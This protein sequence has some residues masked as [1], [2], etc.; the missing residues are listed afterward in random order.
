MSWSFGTRGPLSPGRR[1][2]NGIALAATLVTALAWSGCGT[3][4]GGENDTGCDGTCTQEALTADEV[5]TILAGGVAEAE[6]LGLD[7]TIAVLDRVGNVLA[8]FRMDGAAENTVISSERAGVAEASF[9]QRVVPTAAAAISKAGTGAY[10]SSQ[11][12]AFTTRTASQIVQE[13]FNPRERGRVGGPLFGVQFSQLPCGDVVTRAADGRRNG[14]VGGRVGPHRLPLGLAADPGGLPIYKDATDGAAR[15][16][17]TLV[18]G[19]GVE[20]GCSLLHACGTCTLLA[21]A[22]DADPAA[23]KP[24]R[25]AQSDCS[26]AVERIYGLDADVSGIDTHLEE[27]IAAA[28]VRGFEAPTDRRANRISALGKFL[29]YTDDENAGVGAI[30][31]CAELTGSLVPVDGYTDVDSCAAITGGERLGTADSGILRTTFEGMDAEILVDESGTPRFPPSDGAGLDASEVRTILAEALAITERVRAQ[32]RRPL[33][34]EARVSIAVVDAEGAL[35]GLVRSPDAPVFGIDVAVQ[36]A[37]TAAFFSSPDARSELEAAPGLEVVD[38]ALGA[39][40]LDALSMAPTTDLVSRYVGRLQTF[41]TENGSIGGAPIEA[42][43]VLTGA[44]AFGDRAGG[45]LSRPFYP[46]GINGNA[47]G[48]LSRPFEIWSPFSTGL[49]LDLVF[50]NVALASC[51]GVDA[52]TC[53]SVAALANGIQIFPGSVPIYRGDTLVGG[54]GVSGD[55]V[56]QDDLIAFLGLHEAGLALGG[57][58]GNAPAAR[59]SDRIELGGA[60]LRFVNCPFKPFHDSD[61]QSVCDGK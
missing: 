39:G 51:A 18:G 22:D 10:L 36:K 16:G 23:C 24:V 29:R 31:T 30:E 9:E 52:G 49:Q 34:T 50:A 40:T 5:R 33:G 53:S 2:L 37:R 61:E 19:I 47:N 54:I 28:A 56:D 8:V 1:V 44:V 35:V 6:R 17:R 41:L 26:A 12:N 42:A 60:N 59:R 13:N 46:D 25:D 7:V 32:I 21:D 38:D 58:I 45:N 43:D 48:P 3:G 4:A 57:A 15:S 14:I 20:L 11:G 27:R 55:G